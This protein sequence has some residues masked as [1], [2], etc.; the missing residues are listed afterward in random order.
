VTQENYADKVL[1]YVCAVIAH[2]HVTITEHDKHR[3]LEIIRFLYPGEH[4]IEHLYSQM[5]QDDFKQVKNIREH[6]R[7]AI[8]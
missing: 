2:P 8:K 4:T 7:N 1:R 3:A 6:A 5:N